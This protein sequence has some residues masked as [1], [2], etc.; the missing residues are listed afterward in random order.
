VVKDGEK[1]EEVEEEFDL[2]NALERK[3]KKKPPNAHI[4]IILKKTF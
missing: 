1:E 3:H 2:R 4:I